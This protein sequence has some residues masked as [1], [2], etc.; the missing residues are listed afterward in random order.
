MK[1]KKLVA[2]SFFISAL[3]M[4]QAP[5]IKPPVVVKPA[6]PIVVKPT[7]APA[8]ATAVEAI[9]ARFGPGALPPEPEIDKLIPPGFVGGF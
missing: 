8:E 5:K 4:A 9:D 2:A 6:T 7:S 1:I 3:V